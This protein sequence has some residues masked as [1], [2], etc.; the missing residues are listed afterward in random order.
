[1]YVSHLPFR[2]DVCFVFICPVV[3]WLFCFEGSCFVLKV[4]VKLLSCVGGSND[5]CLAIISF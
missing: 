4:L 1:M 3:T 2:A 5:G